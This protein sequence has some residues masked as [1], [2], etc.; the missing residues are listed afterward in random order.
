MLD[1]SYKGEIKLYKAKFKL[2]YAKSSKWINIFLTIIFVGLIIYLSFKFNLFDKVSE[3]SGEVIAV[4][5]SLLGAVVGGVFTLLGSVYVNQKQLKAQTYIKRKNLIYKPLYDE[6]GEIENVILVDNP[7]PS[8]ITFNQHPQTITKHPQYTVWGRIKSDT[9]Y[10]ETPQE[11]ILEIEKLY[12]CISKYL[13]VRNGNNEYMTKLFNGILNDVLGTQCTIKN[14][15]D[16]LI[17]YALNNKREDISI[18]YSDALVDKIEVT[19]EQN[20]LINSKFYQKCFEDKT[21]LSIMEARKDWD[22]QQKK[23]IELL[24]NL[25]EYVNIKY[26]G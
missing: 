15:G 11:L 2:F 25:I 20:K 3:W 13:R 7:F 24:T 19:D 12:E 18:Y 5:A 10:L 4:I 21:I 26:E 14:I 1:R 8:Y 17:P 6:L 16:C 23:V 22:I 9:R